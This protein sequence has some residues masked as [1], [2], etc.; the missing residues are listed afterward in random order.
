MNIFTPRELKEIHALLDTLVS[1]LL[2]EPAGCLRS[3]GDIEQ[4][5]AAW[6]ALLKVIYRL[7]DG[8]IPPGLA[9][10]DELVKARLGT[11]RSRLAASE[12]QPS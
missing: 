5:A 12:S 2:A 6:S 11:A 8:V 4:L 3:R 9:E 1:Q 7:N 10:R